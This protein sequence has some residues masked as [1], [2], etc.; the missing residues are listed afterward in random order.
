MPA[1]AGTRVLAFSNLFGV[2]TGDEPASVQHGIVA[3]KTRLEP[4]A[5]SFETPYHGPVYVLDAMTNN[6]G[7]AGGR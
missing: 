2:A 3:V 1:E 7:A 4:A 6:P 5:A